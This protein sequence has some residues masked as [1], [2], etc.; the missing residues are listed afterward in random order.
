MLP[1]LGGAVEAVSIAGCGAITAVGN[2]TGA[3]LAAVRANASGL[4]R[5][6]Q[7]SE[8]NVFGGIPGRDDGDDPAFALATQAITEAM[9][10]ARLPAIPAARIGFVLATTKANIEALERLSDGR[11]CS[12][13]A[14]RHLRGDLLAADLAAKHGAAGPVQCVSVAC[15][16]GLVALT[17]GAKLLQRDAADA[18]IVAGVDCLSSFIVAG[19]TSLKALDPSGC[20]PFDRDRC[21]LSPGEAGAAVVLVRGA[22][23]TTI[24][25]WGGSNDANHLT[26]PSRDGS[27]LALAI[28]RALAAAAVSPRD[29]GYVNAHGTGTPYNDAMES[30]ALRTIFEKN[31][32]PVSASKGMFG[33]T[34]GAAGILE[35]IIC[36]L[37][38]RE[39]LLPGTPRLTTPVMPEVLKDPQIGPHVR[40]SLKLGTGF[41]GVNA[42]LVLRHE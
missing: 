9:T 30:L 37:A 7:F 19:F 18:V 12:E 15:I 27:G 5:C 2:D 26:G 39:R 24:A 34:L 29:I 16:S 36:V 4:R 8:P 1:A 25:G 14:R 22:G 32:P 3:L 38:A 13:S 21:G 6:Q 40:H 31:C 35:T 42:A 10:Q 20:R 28:Q 11:P 17:Q 23:A 33:H 41:G